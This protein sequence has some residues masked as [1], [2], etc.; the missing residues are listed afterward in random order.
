MKEIEADFC[1]D[2]FWS[3]KKEIMDRTRASLPSSK[4]FRP[5]TMPKE[6][7]EAIEVLVRYEWYEEMDDFLHSEEE[8]QIGHVFA[9]K[10]L[11]QDWLEHQPDYWVKT[12]S[13]LLSFV[14]MMLLVFFIPEIIWLSQQLIENW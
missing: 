7:F 12:S 11:L 8:H 13:A 6:I 1:D 10:L 9:S 2:Y 14:M 4:C 5:I 3:H